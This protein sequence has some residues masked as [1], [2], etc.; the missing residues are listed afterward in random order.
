M[1]AEN[2]RRFFIEIFETFLSEDSENQLPLTNQALW[3]EL[4]AT[5]SSLKENKTVAP[6]PYPTLCGFVETPDCG[7]KA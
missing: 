6:S 4:R 2:Q 7:T 5:Y 3:D 1:S